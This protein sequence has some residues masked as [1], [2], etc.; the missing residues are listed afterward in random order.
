M[1]SY[2]KNIQEQ[3]TI[4]PNPVNNGFVI[5][6]PFEINEYFITTSNGQ[7]IKKQKLKNVK[8]F[9]VNTSTFNKGTYILTVSNSSKRLSKGFVKD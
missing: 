1:I 5:K 7:Q 9:S 4:T 2:I 3:L 8:V 6:A